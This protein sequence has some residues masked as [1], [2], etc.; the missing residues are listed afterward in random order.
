MG[1]SISN[2]SKRKPSAGSLDS[3]SSSDSKKLSLF[4]R[5]VRKTSWRPS[6]GSNSS[7]SYNSGHGHH[8]VVPSVDH[9]S[10]AH[11]DLSQHSNDSSTNYSHHG[12]SSTA[13]S[14]SPQPYPRMPGS[15][16][17]E[18]AMARMCD[19][20]RTRH[21][22]GSAPYML[23]N[24]MTE[25]DR[26][27]AQHYLVRYVFKGNYNVKLDPKAKLNILDVATGTAVWALEMSHEFPN[28]QIYGVDISPIFPS[29]IKPANCHFQLCNILDGLPFEDNYFDFVYQRL[30]VYALSPSQRKQVYAELLRVL[31]PGGYLQLVESDGVVY[32]GGPQMELINRLSLETPMRHGVDPRVVQTMRSGLKHAG[33]ANVNSFH[34][35]LPVGKWGGKVGELSMQN[36]H[37][38]GNI[39]LKGEIGR[40]S[41]EEAQRVL[42]EAGQECEANQAF[43]K[44]WLVVGQKPTGE[45]SGPSSPTSLGAVPV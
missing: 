14:T 4:Q 5:T 38:L 10:D 28:S 45:S 32:N 3:S 15:A 33:Y 16:L 11:S 21:N 39:W 1:N 2:M 36:M 40:M 41:E 44:V 20:G 8:Q 25:A 6:L 18:W 22:V 13:T 24:D 34:I 31:K 43:Y 19:D 37:G 30:L 23:P 7:D 17:P 9:G 29:E 35:A 26:L 27:D 12:S 42:D